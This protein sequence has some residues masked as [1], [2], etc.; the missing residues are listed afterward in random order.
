MRRERLQIE[1]IVMPRE[2]QPEDDVGRYGRACEAWMTQLRTLAGMSPTG[3]M[4]KRTVELSAGTLA[5]DTQNQIVIVSPDRNHST[6]LDRSLAGISDGPS[7]Q[8]W[9]SSIDRGKLP[10]KFEVREG[11]EYSADQKLETLLKHLHGRQA[12]ESL[13]TT[14]TFDL[15]LDAMPA[16]DP[17]TFTMNMQV[18]TEQS[19]A[20]ETER[21]RYIQDHLQAKRIAEEVN[22]Q[23]QQRSLDQ[24][25]KSKFY[26]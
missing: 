1:N 2:L 11:Q 5:R 24:E 15:M 10:T 12:E 20:F 18:R 7:F 21:G 17:R 26:R 13:R 3:D 16:K 14:K 19:A 25:F 22:T 23:E 9:V 6:V 8:R 4:F